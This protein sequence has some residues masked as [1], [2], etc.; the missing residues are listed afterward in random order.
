MDRE[1]WIAKEIRDCR[2]LTSRCANRTLAVGGI[3]VYCAPRVFPH[4]NRV[5]RRLVD[6]AREVQG[7]CALDLGCGTGVLGLVLARRFQR[8]VC[9]DRCPRA[10]A[11]A[12]ANALIHGLRQISVLSGS[13]FKPVQ[14]LTFDAV[15]CNPPLYPGGDRDSRTSY[16]TIADSLIG[17]FVTG[18]STALTLNG[19]GLLATSSLTDNDWIE[20]NLGRDRSLRVARSRFA[21]RTRS[22]QDIYIW[23]ITKTQPR[24]ASL[25]TV[26]RVADEP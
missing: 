6:A 21:G 13:G 16:G 20:E 10:V 23:R 26:H 8:V 24:G 5:T 1:M 9:V 4:A 11:C 14:G 3:A 2:R 12:R 18:L 7:E 15:V 19:V 25:R 17:D 22:S